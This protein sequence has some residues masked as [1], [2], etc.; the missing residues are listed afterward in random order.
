MFIGI[1]DGK[2]VDVC[3]DLI[4]SNY[5][6]EV[7]TYLDIEDEKYSNIFPGDTWDFDNN[8]SLKD[9]PQRTA[10]R[11]KSAQELKIE[12]LEAKLASQELRLKALEDK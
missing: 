9:A 10:Q 12:Q 8:V 1:I 3:S 5:D 4:N 6:P 11:V 2:V 7:E